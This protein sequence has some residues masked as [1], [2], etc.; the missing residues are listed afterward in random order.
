MNYINLANNNSSIKPE[1]LR[2]IL[3]DEIATFKND[4]LNDI[5]TKENKK[6]NSDEDYSKWGPTELV[7]LNKIKLATAKNMSNSWSNIPQVTQFEN[8]DITNLYRIYKK[9][10]Y[11]IRIQKLKFL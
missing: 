4:V 10:N 1:D 8:A 11:Q 9:L 6:S 7:K 2:K 3:K 5:S